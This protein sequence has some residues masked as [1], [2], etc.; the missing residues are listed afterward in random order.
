MKRILVTG[1][2]FALIATSL[3]AAPR[4]RR[5]RRRAR[6]TNSQSTVRS[7][8]SSSN[9]Y[10]APSATTQQPSLAQTRYTTPAYT[11]PSSTPQSFVTQSNVPTVPTQTTVSPQPTTAP[12]VYTPLPPKPGPITATGLAQTITAYK[13]IVSEPA[14]EPVVVAMANTIPAVGPI[15]TVNSTSPTTLIPTVQPSN[16]Q[17]ITAAALAPIPD[18]LPSLKGGGSLTQPEPFC[19]SC[20]VIPAGKSFNSA[21]AELNRIRASKGLRALIEDQSLS[22]IA[23]QK[24]SIQ[25]NRGAMYHPGGSMGGARY[26]GVGMGPRFTT[27]YQD[28]TNVTYAGAATVLGRNGTRYHCL[29]VR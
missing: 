22:A 24:A 8:S 27:C 15:P 17:V 1:M 13:P 7:N 20:T 2:L 6:Q 5:A 3:D 10:R 14:S 29:L 26:E 19:A 28:A 21:L 12:A 11:A 25:A 9:Y 16:N 23:H 4:G 18:P